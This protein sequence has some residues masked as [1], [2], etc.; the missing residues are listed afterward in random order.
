M[1]FQ[2]CTTETA[3]EKLIEALKR[4]KESGEISFVLIIG[5]CLHHNKGNNKGNLEEIKFF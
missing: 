2:N 3:K 1:Q 4:E 5:D